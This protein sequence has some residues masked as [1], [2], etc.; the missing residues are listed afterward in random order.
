M[1]F[2]QRLLERFGLA[3]SDDASDPYRCI[4]CGSTFERQHH[5]CP[6]CGVP[7]VVSE[8]ADE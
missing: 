3:D 4:R 1:S 2:V 6:E 8:D 7:Y 5:D